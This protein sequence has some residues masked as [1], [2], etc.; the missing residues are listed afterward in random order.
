[1]HIFKK[2]KI[3]IKEQKSKNVM[4]NCMFFETS[5]LEAFGMDLE[6]VWEAKISVWRLKTFQNEE[7]NR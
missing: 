4:K 7:L 5:I 1:M 2:S 6:W 3:K